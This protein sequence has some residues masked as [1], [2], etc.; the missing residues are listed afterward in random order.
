MSTTSTSLPHHSGEKH[1]GTLSDI[2]NRDLLEGGAPMGRQIS[3][4]LT[5]EQFERLYLEPGGRKSK[6]DLSKRF[7][8]PTPLGLASFLLCLTPFSC[9][10]MGWARTTAGSAPTLVGAMLFMGGLGL[11]IAG[12]LEYFLGNTFTVV[13]FCTF[14][15]FWLSFGFLLA[16]QQN[17]ANAVGATTADYNGGIA[18]YLVWWSIL[19]LI[20]TIASLRTNVVFVLLFS[21]LE[22]DFCLLSALY[23]KVALGRLDMIE[24]IT[25]AAGAF[26]FLTCCMGWYLLV[27][28]VFDSTG[29]PIKLP[30]GDLSTFMA[31]GARKDPTH[32]A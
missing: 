16:P 20:Y 2:D 30:V 12:I 6:G 23:T 4:Q 32:Q 8:N 29:M 5:Q 10:L 21:F 18:M 27:V 9:Y 22:V 24:G 31:R 3:I 17:I 1:G 26:G 25:K 14:G 28:L 13:V 11:W 19:N 7:A 15:S